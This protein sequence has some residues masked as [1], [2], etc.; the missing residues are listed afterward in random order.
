MARNLVKI[1]LLFV[2]ILL[3]LQCLR[4][5]HS[6]LAHWIDL[7]CIAAETGNLCLKLFFYFIIW[8]LFGQ[9]VRIKAVTYVTFSTY[10]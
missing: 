2:E 9:M 6:V 8:Y 10:A 4:S 3:L 7:P 5:Y 1:F